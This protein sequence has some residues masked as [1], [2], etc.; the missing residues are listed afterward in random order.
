M[1]YSFK[2]VKNFSDEL[3]PI[4][5][6]SY[7]NKPKSKSSTFT[8]ITW[9]IKLANKTELAIS[10]IN[11]IPCLSCFDILL[12]QEMDLESVK[13][14]S[15]AFQAYYF[16][17]PA[18][19]NVK[20]NRLFGNAII[21][22]Y[23]LNNP[24]K[25]ILPYRSSLTGQTRLMLSASF[26]LGKKVINVHS[27]HTELTILTPWTRTKHRAE[28]FNG[29]MENKYVIIGGDFNT[30]RKSTVKKLTRSASE[31][32]FINISKE[33][34]ATFHTSVLTRTLDHLFVK[35][36]TIIKSGVIETTKASDHYPVW[37][38]LN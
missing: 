30:I 25:K 28:I 35:G 31:K 32:G 37:A 4:Y 13:I 36:L 11:K 8:V 6:G 9:N 14:I 20:T 10:E 33:D 16:Y 7:I 3:S 1:K 12:L 23:K 38:E 22:R 34:V 29:N 18:H 2:P 26:K 27:V 24:R 19:I 5:S 15:R 21:S 17:A